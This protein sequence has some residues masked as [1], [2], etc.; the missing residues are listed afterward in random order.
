MYFSTIATVLAATA[1]FASAAA[2]EARG[3]TAPSTLPAQ[4]NFVWKLTNFKGHRPKGTYFDSISFDVYSTTEN[5]LLF[6]CSHSG[7]GPMDE[8]SYFCNIGVNDMTFNYNRDHGAGRD[9]GGIALTGN[10]LSDKGTIL[11]GTTYIPEVC[12][13]NG[14]GD[15]YTCTGTADAYINMVKFM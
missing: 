11:L 13:L 4:G 1:G 5:K 8:R 12:K 15:D 7:S 9:F 2:I 10:L 3:N 14:H 6:S